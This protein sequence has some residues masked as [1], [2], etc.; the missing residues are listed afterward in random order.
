MA[1]GLMLS[2]QGRWRRCSLLMYDN[3]RF[4]RLQ[5]AI[6]SALALTSTGAWAERVECS[7]APAQAVDGDTEGRRALDRDSRLAGVRARHEAE[8]MRHPGVVGVAQGVEVRQGK[9]GAAPCLVIYFDKEAADAG[10]GTLPGEID[11]IA[12]HIIDVG[13]I[14]ALPQRQ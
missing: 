10:A 8:L 4:R 3:S 13:K 7:A 14:E 1:F 5:L 11:G 9:P 12:V 2:M 6:V